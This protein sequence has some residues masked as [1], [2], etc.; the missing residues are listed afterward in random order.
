M[1]ALKKILF[2]ACCL[3]LTAYIF[4]LSCQIDE[5]SEKKSY[6]DIIVKGEFHGFSIIN[7]LISISSES[8]SLESVIFDGLIKI[9]D[10]GEPQPNLASLW[11]VSEDGLT[12][13]FFISKGVKFHDG[14]ELTAE[15]ILFTYESIKKPENKGRYYSSFEF[16]E[17]IRG[18][19]RYTIEI[20]LK[21]PYV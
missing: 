1:P 14:K 4:L 15:D 8:A 20:I 19:D 17:N 12:W 6:G 13:T 16:V 7:P 3:L 18:I 5:P 9:D 10:K 2:S 21:K 11:K